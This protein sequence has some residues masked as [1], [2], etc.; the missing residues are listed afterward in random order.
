MPKYEGGCLCGK[1]RLELNDEPELAYGCH[2][3][4]CQR[5]TGTAFRSGMRYRK[6]NVSL[7]TVSL[8]PTFILALNT[9]GH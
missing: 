5:A 4:F 8:K 2:C 9:G 3:R 6:A 1:V 7:M